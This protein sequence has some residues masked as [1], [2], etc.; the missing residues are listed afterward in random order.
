MLKRDIA[1]TLAS[2]LVIPIVGFL[3]SVLVARALGPSG[4]GVLA[5]ALL[6][7][8]VLVAFGRWGQENVNATYAGRYPERR[9]QLLLQTIGFSVLGGAICGGLVLVWY[10]FRPGGAFA[11][12][13][14]SVVCVSAC[15]PFSLIAGQLVTGL[16]RGTGRVQTAAFL[17]IVQA[18]LYAA[19]IAA[20]WYANW[21]TIKSVIWILFVTTLLGTAGGLWVL[22][23]S[24][25][26]WTTE[27][28]LGFLKRSLRFGGWVM[29]TT[30]A[31]FLVYRADQGILGYMV[32][33]A[34]VGW[35][36][37]AVSLAEQLKLVPNSISSAF[38]PYLANNAT[39]AQSMVP[40]VFRLTLISGCALLT[41]FAVIGAVG[42]PFV[43][44][45]GFASSVP[46][47]LA[48]LPGVVFL[49]AGSVLVGDLLVRDMPHLGALRSWI[50]L[51]L[52]IV[53]N[54][55]LIPTLGILGA[56]LASTVSYFVAFLLN[57]YFY[58]RVTG[59]AWQELVPRSTDVRDILRTVG[60]VLRRY[61]LSC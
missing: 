61:P 15:L 12:V 39:V 28:S 60:S 27:L 14:Q 36:A 34:E 59:V 42:I 2:N 11:M 53:L 56:A 10:T 7:P 22:L 55:I 40:R 25:D 29:L 32:T 43:Y 35:Y 50:S 6:V 21:L 26:K 37:I 45:A 20:I 18:L 13:P 30:A 31:G 52:N 47:F 51:A 24:D 57:A 48:L 38:V 58:L 54:L 3:A 5:I 17:R 19:V 49:G 9:R 16:V 8:Q 41:G 1:A 23:K 4:R 46:P 44:G 33:P